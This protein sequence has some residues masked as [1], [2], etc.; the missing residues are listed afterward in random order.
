MYGYSIDQ[1]SVSLEKIMQISF[2]VRAYNNSHTLL[3]YFDFLLVV[4]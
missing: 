1:L 4:L 2:D 3:Y